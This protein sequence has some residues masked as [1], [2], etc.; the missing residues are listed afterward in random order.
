MKWGGNC[1]QLL[2]AIGTHE[3]DAK[4]VCL[5]LSIQALHLLAIATNSAIVLFVAVA[6]RMSVWF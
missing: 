5:D 6:K 3:F 2:V 1:I 4:L